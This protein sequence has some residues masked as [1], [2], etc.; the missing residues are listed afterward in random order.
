MLVCAYVLALAAVAQAEPLMLT[1]LLKAGKL[2]EAREQ[3]Q[4]VVDGESL[5]NSGFFSVAS[6]SGKNTNNFFFWF[7][8][9]LDGCDP[10][11]T[12]LVQWMQGGPGAPSTFGAMAEIGN[13]YVEEDLTIKKRCFSWCRTRNCLFVDS[14]TMTGFSYQVNAT[15]QYDK[16]HI[17]Y[18][19]TSQALAVQLHDLLLQFLTVWPE[20]QPAPYWVTGESYGGIYIPWMAKTI[21]EKNV[22]SN[23]KVN[24]KGISVG[25][26][27]LDARVQWP[28]YATTLHAMGLIMGDERDQ[29]DAVLKK[30]VD[31]L[32]KSCYSAFVQW[33][34]VW[35][36][37][38][39]SSCAPNC[40][41]F[42]KNMSGSPMTE[43]SLLGYNPPELNYFGTYLQAHN[44]DFHFD[45]IPAA[46][47]DEGGD[48]YLTMVKSG[49]FCQNSAKLYTELFLQA[50]LEV[51]VYSSTA[52]PL[53]GPPTTEAGIKSAWDYA[54]ASIPGGDKA[55][56]GYY[57]AK[58]NL[59]SVAKKDVE[60]S[61][62]SKCYTSDKQKRF[63]YTIV[64]N[65]GHMTP[66]FM[67]R[68]S[69]DMAERFIGG[70]PF[71]A[72]WFD[73]KSPQCAQCGGTVPLA[74]KAL[75]ACAAKP[76]VSF[77]ET[78]V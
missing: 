29:L 18:T 19:A 59:W 55:S 16:A 43:N 50:G 74:G 5:G 63:C 77:M 15:G 30:G 40:D 28:T 75:P 49:D 66:S 61:G 9:C 24:I 44:K 69:Y 2:K 60:L 11:S 8:P 57:R 51:N 4:V 13:W 70:H 33:N 71:D 38:G 23:P 65:A 52:D 42:F 47:L 78:V 26:P 34:R 68:A 12:P 36:D 73:P 64:R 45:G 21:V 7:Q 41:F 62:Y 67:P 54:K 46:Q 14:P 58:K 22:F 3:S 35:M 31:M 37:D 27:V 48:I 17:E 25:D 6:E 76:G 20:Y 56:A 72:T 32:S 39:G 10:K 1:P 53:L